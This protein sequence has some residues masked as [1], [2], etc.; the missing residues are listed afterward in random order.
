ESGPPVASALHRDLS[1][2]SRLC[3][4]RADGLS[5]T[6]GLALADSDQEELLALPPRASALQSRAPRR[7]PGAALLLAAG[8]HHGKALWSGASRRGT[9]VARSGGVVC[10]Q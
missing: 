2:R 1:G 3:G 7:S 9:P 4:Y 6:S 5:P 10:A 8:V